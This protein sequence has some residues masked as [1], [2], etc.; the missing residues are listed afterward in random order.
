MSRSDE[1]ESASRMVR[2]QRF[3][4]VVRE[5]ARLSCMIVL[6]IS[7]FTS[8]MLMFVEDRRSQLHVHTNSVDW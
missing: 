3:C 4:K 1:S 8:P 2:D 7:I 6:G 5:H